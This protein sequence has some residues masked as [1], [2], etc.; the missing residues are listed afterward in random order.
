MP[1]IAASIPTTVCWYLSCS[2]SSDWVHIPLAGVD[3]DVMIFRGHC[4][5]LLPMLPP[6]VL[7]SKRLLH[8]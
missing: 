6:S 5:Y 8:D 7:W 1:S 3:Y 2:I 4:H